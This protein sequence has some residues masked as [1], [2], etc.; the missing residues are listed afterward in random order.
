M[1]VFSH[2]PGSRISSES[3]SRKPPDT[4][5]LAGRNSNPL[6]HSDSSGLMVAM[7]PEDDHAKLHIADELASLVGT[8]YVFDCRD[9]I[10]ETTPIWNLNAFWQDDAVQHVFRGIIRSPSVYLAESVDASADQVKLDVI[11]DILRLR[12]LESDWDG[13][14]AE[15]INVRSI[16]RAVSFV[17][18]MPTSHTIIPVVVPMSGGRLQLEWHTKTRSLELEF[19]S[20]SQIHYLKCDEETGFDEEDVLSSPEEWNIANEL[21]AWIT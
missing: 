9:H 5:T 20:P 15:I 3:F 7:L 8:E 4:S 11:S 1:A 14:G 13:A 17:R 16:E 12:L 10:E 2:S 6:M 18:Q 21:V 19:E